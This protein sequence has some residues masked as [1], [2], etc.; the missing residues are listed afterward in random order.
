MEPVSSLPLPN[1]KT[2]ASLVK[3]NVASDTAPVSAE[4]VKMA[5]VNK[6]VD[7]QTNLTRI[8]NALLS[9]NDKAIKLG[10]RTRTV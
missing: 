3:P 4:T 10:Q 9:D 1:T 8:E 5:S 7:P 2:T 6:N